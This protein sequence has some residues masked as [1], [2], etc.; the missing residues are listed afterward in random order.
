MA[1][2]EEIGLVADDKLGGREI[3]EGE[4]ACDVFWEGREGC[5]LREREVERCFQWSYRSE[6]DIDEVVHRGKF[7][8]E[9]LAE[10]HTR[11]H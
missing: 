1:G 4:T 2:M 8:V 7:D 11:K 10:L 5:C 6:D 9:N 3:G